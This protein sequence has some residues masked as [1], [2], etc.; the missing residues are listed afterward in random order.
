MKRL[1]ECVP[2]F[3]EGR[4]LSKV[5]AIAA[6]IR[7]VPEVFLL[8]RESDADHNRSVI[9]LA[10]DPEG[11]VEAAVR[12]VGKAS[13]L[14]DLTRQTG[15]HPRIGATD[16][17][18][19]IPLE[20]VSL[21]DCVILAKKAGREI[22]ERYRIPVFFYEAAAQ[23]PDRVNLENIRRG[24]F[25][26]LREEIL[27]NP[28]R[29]PDV[30]DARLHPTAGGTVVGAR[31]F[32]I[33]YNINLNTPDVA[34][35]KKI[36]KTIRFSSG[37]LP[38]VKA[39]GVDLRARNLA[40]VSMNLTDFEQTPIHLVFETVKREA[41]RLGVG[42]VGSEIVGLIPRRAIEMTAENYLKVENFSPAQ[43]LENRLE[44]SLME[45][46]ANASLA[47]IV[48]PFLEALAQ[49]TATPGGGS[50]SALAGA[51]AASLGQM[52]AGLSSI[53]KSGAAHKERLDEAVKEF[54]AASRRLA[55]AIDRDAESFQSVMAAYRLPNGTEDDREQRHTA[56]Q[57]ALL[58]AIEAP[59]EIAREAA[60]LFERL[61]QLESLSSPSMLSDVRVAR[62]MASASVRG[63]LENV[64][65]NLQSVTDARVDER[66][67]SECRSLTLRITESP[68]EAGRKDI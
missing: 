66:V 15:A 31:K 50:A 30:G 32:L 55:A 44:E 48:T 38:F 35:A 56:I 13:E 49:P 51:L 9:T 21:E 33:A 53:K 54:D 45:S 58:D 52:V 1:V 65:I 67:R 11:I 26:G 41:E 19:F 39:M 18:P 34:I 2:N 3:A 36:A 12:A 14:I 60:Q 4:D 47:A 42:I 46:G 62:L 17:V 24:Q 61:G 23:R 22:W 43:V 16:V 63:A 25:E 10:G 28:E 7:E 57:N 20:G 8:A 5:D 6:A 29:A 64:A 37:G 68:S 27:R 59:L 40:Q